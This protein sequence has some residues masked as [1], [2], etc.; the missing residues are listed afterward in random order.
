MLPDA[1]LHLSAT[2][3]LPAPSTATPWRPACRRKLRDTW[4]TVT[5]QFQKSAA[6]DYYTQ[7]V[8]II[9]QC[10]I[11]GWTRLGAG[12]FRSPV[13]LRGTPYRI[14]FLT[15]QWLLTVVGNKLKRGTICELLNTLSAV[16]TLHDS[17]L[18]KFTTDFDTDI[19]ILA[20]TYFFRLAFDYSIDKLITFPPLPLKL[21]L[22]GASYIS[23]Y[24]YYYY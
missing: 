22:Y 16:G 21:R 20:E 18:Y 12:P 7:P 3:Y 11:T 15:Q 10:R 8:D 23:L 6:V 17:A 14:V 13:L 2:R 9:L 5:H 1:Q 24:Y 4:S 19:Q